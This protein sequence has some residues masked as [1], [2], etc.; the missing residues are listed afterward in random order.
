MCGERCRD[1]VG[2]GGGFHCR[3]AATAGVERGQ[4]LGQFVGVRQVAVVAQR[5]VTGGRRAE[6]RLSV[7]PNT[8]S[9]RGVAG[10]ADGDVA[11]QGSRAGESEK[12][13]ETRPMS[14]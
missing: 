14:L 11:V 12:T 1:Q 4:A 9:R 2:V 3:P 13:W 6:G 8:G 5:D 7:L 10:V